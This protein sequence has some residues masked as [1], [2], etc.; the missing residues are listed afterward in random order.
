LTEKLDFEFFSAPELYHR[1]KGG[2]KAGA[3]LFDK[4]KARC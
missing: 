3:A 4:R 1:G 2:V